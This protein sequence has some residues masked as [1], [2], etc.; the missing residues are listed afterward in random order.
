M[1]YESLA[2]NIINAVGGEKNVLN[3]YHCM[4]RLRFKVKDESLV[5]KKEVEVIEGVI[6]LIISNGQYQV[7]IGNHVE[8]VCDTIL[9][10]YS[11]KENS[12]EKQEETKISTSN[13]IVKLFNMMSSILAPIVPLLAGSGMIKALLV[14]FTTYC[15][16]ENSS[17]TYKILAAAGNSVFY[18]FPIMIAFSAAK[19]FGVNIYIA[20]GIMGALIEPN[21]TSLMKKV[22]DITSFAGIPVVLMSYTSTIFPAILSVWVYSYVERLL[23]KIIPKN[24]EIFMI[25]FLALLIM[26]PLTMMVIGPVGVTLGNS[27]GAAIGFLSAKSGVLTGAI[28]GAG[29]T[30]LVMFGIHWGVVPIM[31]NNIALYGFD[32][33]RPA[34]ATATFAQAGAAFGVFLKAK[35]KKNKTFAFSA[36]LPA[37]L[38]G[39]TEPIVYGI[40]VKYKTP[41]Y[42]AVISGAIAGGFVGSMKTT[43]M[44]YVFPALTTL[45]A[46]MTDTFLFYIIGIS[47]AFFLTTGITYFLGIEEDDVPT[48]KE[49]T[50]KE[51]VKEKKK[52]DFCEGIK[53]YEVLAPVKGNA[54]P[55]AKVNDSVFSTESVGKGMAIEPADGNVYAPV[56]GVVT[57]VFPTGHALGI[58]ADNG[59]EIM[60]HIGIDTVQLEGKY[61]AAKVKNGENIKKGQLLIQFD[62]D[63]IKKSGYEITTMVVATNTEKYLDVLGTENTAVSKE[64]ILFTVIK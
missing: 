7:V 32:T 58:T 42:A 52:T 30:F 27:L 15:G 31:I 43:V 37:L 62:K 39:I 2:E 44:V 40:S 16:M 23:K 26:V 20:A 6:S 13:P 22:G 19:T 47:A 57:A 12:I 63:N 64:D 46:F 34:V 18:L 38:G 11:I 1:K 56:D 21:F 17:S 49:E 3:L 50:K 4:T 51:F 29:W 5:N 10:L 8:E 41:M 55:L 61:F 60:I 28:I 24:I 14:I 45:P 59:L 35:Q 33:I 54:I 53:I 9:S 25:S 36:M 48:E